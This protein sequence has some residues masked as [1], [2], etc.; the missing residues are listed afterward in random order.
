MKLN[1]YKGST[2][3]TVNIFIADSSSTTGNGLGLLTYSSSGLICYY[4]SPGRVPTKINLVNQTPT[5]AWISG[6]FCEIDDPYMLGWYRLDLPNAVLSRTDLGSS[7][8]NLGAESVG[9]QLSGAT[10]MVPCNLEIQ[11]IDKTVIKG[12]VAAGTLTTT[13]FTTNLTYAN[14]VL[15][16]RTLIF[17]TGSLKGNSVLIT[18]Y[19]LASGQI[20]C[21]PLTGNPSANDEF[22]IV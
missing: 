6:G 18:N 2:S 7:E 13:T 14:N 20:W 19:A 4:V 3:Q 16:N 1:V 17:T 5:G 10:N 8:F 9:I 21:S 22:V 15:N 12:K 11:L